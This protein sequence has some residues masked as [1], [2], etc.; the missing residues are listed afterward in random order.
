MVKIGEDTDMKDIQNTQG[1]FRFKID[2]VGVSNVLHPV[3]LKTRDGIMNTIGKFTMGVCLCPELKGI[4]MSRLP[5]FLAD[6]ANR[7]L[8]MSD[9]RNVIMGILETMRE[10][11]ESAEA[12]MKIEF[13]YF[14]GRKAPVSGFEGL[15]PYR[16]KIETTLENWGQDKHF[17]YILSVEVPITTLCPCSKAISDNS[18]HN[19]RGYVQVSI[20]YNSLVWIEEIIDIV[21]SIG[22]CEIYPILKRV[23]EKYVTEKAYKNPRF[24]EDI[25][26]LVAEKLCEDA[27]IDWFRINSRHQ[28]S[29]HP[30]DAYAQLEAWKQPEKF[31]RI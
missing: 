2:K 23:D 14:L 10:K 6:F 31:Y 3:T 5:I 27:R 18:A 22:S 7:E 13:D 29:I 4:N 12:Y 17:D 1:D 20:R 16:C 25:V 9:I 8:A 19:Q 28:E 26:R 21:N 15:M 11:L 30:H 24:V